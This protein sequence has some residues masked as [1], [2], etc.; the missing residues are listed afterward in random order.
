METS[1]K[2]WTVS[3][4]QIFLEVQETEAELA[5]IRQCT[6]TGRLLGSPEFIKSLEESTRRKLEPRKGG[7]H[8]K[9]TL[10]LAQEAIEFE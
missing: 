10:D 7:R 8:S 5:A 3:R 4:W 2:Q 6:H 9:P 1:T